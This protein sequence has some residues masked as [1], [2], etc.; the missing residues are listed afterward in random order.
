MRDCQVERLK[1]GELRGISKKG[2]D[3]AKWKD[4]DSSRGRKYSKIKTKDNEM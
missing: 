1:Y 4:R 2:E 3:I